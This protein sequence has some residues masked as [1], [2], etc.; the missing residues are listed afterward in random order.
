MTQVPGAGDVAASQP[1]VVQRRGHERPIAAGV[2]QP[3][4]I[5]GPASIISTSGPALVPTRASSNTI[6]DATPA[7]AASST[8][9]SGRVRPDTRCRLDTGAPSRRSR[10]NDTWAGPEM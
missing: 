8:I 3:F 6:T 9:V 2:S 1:P 4:Q 10:L 7:A 5:V